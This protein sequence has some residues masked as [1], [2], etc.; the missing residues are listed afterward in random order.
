[1][2]YSAGGLGLTLS[3]G[4]RSGGSG[5]DGGKGGA[6]NQWTLSGL[7]SVGPTAGACTTNYNV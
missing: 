1:M 3:Y 2:P 5:Q 6:P 7:D 4:F